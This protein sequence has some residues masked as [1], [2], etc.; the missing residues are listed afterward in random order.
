M[1]LV[2]L[3]FELDAHDELELVE[4]DSIR[5]RFI[6]TRTAAVILMRFLS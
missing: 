3:E 6:V 4:P 2:E 5:L 1:E